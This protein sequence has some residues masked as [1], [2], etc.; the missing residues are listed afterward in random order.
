MARVRKEP[1]ERMRRVYT[2]PFHAAEGC[3]WYGPTVQ[4]LNRH[5]KRK[6]PTAP[7]SAK[8]PRK[9]K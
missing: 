1:W 9:S 3:G 6:H 5:L 4:S 7:G 2:C 8:Q